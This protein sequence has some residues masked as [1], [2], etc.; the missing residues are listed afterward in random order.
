M[1]RWR[2]RSKTYADLPFGVEYVPGLGAVS[3]LS[4]AARWLLAGEYAT[5]HRLVGPW[6]GR[7]CAH[8]GTKG[9]CEFSEWATGVL[10]AK[11]RRDW[12][13]Q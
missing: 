8:C 2:A 11:A 13:G 4:K 9:G 6:Y 10:T 7:V 3:E 12:L 1:L 5:T